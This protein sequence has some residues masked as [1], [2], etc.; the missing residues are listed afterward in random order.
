[1]A[2]CLVCGGKTSILPYLFRFQRK[3]ECSHCGARLRIKP[4]SVLFLAILNG[5]LVSLIG[6]TAGV[7][8]EYFKWLSIFLVWLFIF[9]LVY[10]ATAELEEL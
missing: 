1:M 4:R 5:I 10:N 2:K 8:G 6:L 7:T 9:L 3:F